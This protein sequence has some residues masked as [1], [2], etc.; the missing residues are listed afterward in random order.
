MAFVSTSADGEASGSPGTL[1]PPPAVRVER[2][3]AVVEIILARPEQANALTS[4]MRRQLLESLR[5]AGSDPSVGAVLLT[6]SG[7]AFSAGQELREHAAELARAGPAAVRRGLEEEYHPLLLELLASPK[8]VVAALNGAC[9]GAALGIALAC[10]VRLAADSARIVMGFPAIGLGPDAGVSWLLPRSVGLARARALLCT[11]RVLTAEEA[12]QLGLVDL[13]VPAGALQGEARALAT[14]LAAGPTSAY[15]ATRRALLEHAELGLA[16]ALA[17]E[18][19]LQER[20]A[21][22]AD[23]AEGVAAFLAKRRPRFEGH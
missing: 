17:G 19:V 4:A 20:L 23:H 5:A 15:I 12:Y 3:D 18:A 22:T 10:D 8:P 2:H 11:D 9:A 16:E 6:G 1:Q 14:R 13:V 21:G 7:R